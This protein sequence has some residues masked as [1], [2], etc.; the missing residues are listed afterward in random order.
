MT[1]EPIVKTRWVPLPTE[2]AFALFTQRMY[3]WWPVSTHSIGANETDV[4]TLAIRFEGRVGGRVM[5]ILSDGREC[6]WGGR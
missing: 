3:T 1:V 5:E 6:S 4:T 2:E